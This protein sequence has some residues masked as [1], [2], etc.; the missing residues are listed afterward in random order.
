MK[1]IAFIILTFILVTPLGFSQGLPPKKLLDTAKVKIFYTIEY[2]PDSTDPGNIRKEHMVLLAGENISKFMSYNNYY[3]DSLFLSNPSADPTLSRLRGPNRIRSGHFF[4]IFK[5]HPKG[6]ITTFDRV[7]MDTYKYEE[8]ADLF[9]WKLQPGLDTIMGYEVQLAT[10]RFGGRHWQAWFARDIPISDGPYKF[11]GLPG[12]ILKLTDSQNHYTF[13]IQSLSSLP[14]LGEKIFFWEM[15]YFNTT[16]KG[17]FNARERYQKD[18]MS[19]ILT[20]ELP[21]HESTDFDRIQ[22]NQRRRNNPIELT[23]D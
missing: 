16:K 9:R 17:F 21:I 18:I 23:A 14:G 13:K 2:Q 5:D 3:R 22:E 7:F 8:P 1:K 12:L 20:S 6:M 4:T 19:G 15:T 11:H 10:T